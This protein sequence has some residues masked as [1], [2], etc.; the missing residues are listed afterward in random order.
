MLFRSPGLADE[1]TLRALYDSMPGDQATAIPWYVRLLE[2]PASPLA[3]PGAIDLFGHDCIH[4]LL[5]RGMLPQDEEF[6]IGFT[7]A[8][9]GK[10]SKWQQ[11]LFTLCACYIYRSTYRFSGTDRRVFDLAADFA[12]QCG[13]RP[14][15]DI[16]WREMVD[17]E[18]G[19]VRASVGIEVTGLIT[20]YEAEIALCPGSD[21][22]MRLPRRDASVGS[23]S[24][25]PEA[26]YPSEEN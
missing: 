20:V 22:S 23:D 11:R 4:I 21:A 14:V 26:A 25:L 2:N 7:M 18:I 9:S 8:A 1:P 13:A 10:L 24:C 6:V 17:W 3:L 5:G 15:H 16:A 12:I 19:D